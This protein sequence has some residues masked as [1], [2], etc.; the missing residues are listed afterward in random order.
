[1]RPTLVLAAISYVGGACGFMPWDWNIGVAGMGGVSHQTITRNAFQSR[2]ASYWPSLTQNGITSSMASA[3]DSIA[4][5]NGMV[6]T[7]QQHSAL[8]FD[9]ENFAGGQFVITGYGT[10]TDTLP[11][12]EVNLLSQILYYLKTGDASSARTALGRACH[13]IQD[14][15]SHSNYVDM[16][17]TT[18]HG[19]LGRPGSLGGA[20]T[21]EN[22][23]TSCG[24][25]LLSPAD[26]TTC[27]NNC[28]W[29]PAYSLCVN[30][31]QCNDC[32]KNLVTSSLTSGYW[33]D[34]DSV[35]AT[36]V[37]KC[38][39]GGDV[40]SSGKIREGIN[41]D[42]YDCSWSSH[43]PSYHWIAQSLAQQSTERF[44]DD[45]KASITSSY[46]AAVADQQ[47]KLLFG[48]GS[49]LA[50]VVDTTAS[51]SDIIGTVSSQLTQVVNERVNT[52]SQPGT[53]VFAPFSDTWN[54]TPATTSDPSTF[55]QWLSWLWAYG[56]AT[57]AEAAMQGVL[58]AI[59]DV[60]PGSPLFLI[61]DGPPSDAHLLSSV[62]SAANAKNIK[63]FT[64]FFQ[65]SCTDDGTYST[66]A[67]STGG[68]FYSLARNEANYI[69]G[70]IDYWLNS[71]LTPTFSSSLSSS[72]LKRSNTDVSYQ[73]PVCGTTSSVQFVI[74]GT[75]ALDL[76]NPRGT[77]VNG[78][79]P[80]VSITTIS[81]AQIITIESPTS[82]SWNVTLTDTSDCN[83]DVV[84]RSP[85][86]FSF[87]FAEYIGRAGHAGW[88]PNPK[89]V[90][91][92]GVDMPCLAYLDGSNVTNVTFQIRSS[93]G[94]ILVDKVPL[95]QGNDTLGQPANTFFGYIN[96]PNEDCLIYVTG[97]D[98]GGYQFLR[99]YPIRFTPSLNTDSAKNY[100]PPVAPTFETFQS[101]VLPYGA[102][103]SQSVYQPEPPHSVSIPYQA[104][105][106]TIPTLQAQPAPSV[107]NPSGYIGIQLTGGANRLEG[108]GILL[109]GV[110]VGMIWSSL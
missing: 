76:V 53:F 28:W 4:Y 44:I 55:T 25:P 84:T 31:C 35:P 27:E 47:M 26:M 88:A 82:G 78:S 37:N 15:Y 19:G 36:G 51:M 79:D 57:C 5:A 30:D 106:Q 34:E 81:S 102:N 59:P 41:K 91:V 14:F 74:R 107:L 103:D 2:A 90:A 63:I 60:D 9:G 22:T 69:A 67:S 94:D 43:G 66:L 98:A 1:M 12:N 64:L 3:R 54:L 62:V 75:C 77:S 56:G 16:G 85:I 70:W 29:S 96:L 108:S 73:I 104:Y 58:N 80:G 50:F 105:I 33:H 83:F 48:V 42:S 13:T 6:D 87:S 32:S 49:V 68:Q 95:T 23:C 46:G 17:Y 18:P 8:H 45:I 39:H 92:P 72:S 100:T 101:G 89:I 65:S 93:A 7:D 38:Y 97:K 86:I 24:N 52:A 10:Q 61:T 71:D 20:A 99:V 21:W 40:D 11:S 110:A 109:L